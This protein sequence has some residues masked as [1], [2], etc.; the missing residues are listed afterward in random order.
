VWRKPPLV[1]DSG[2]T[3]VTIEASFDRSGYPVGD[4]VRVADEGHP[5]RCVLCER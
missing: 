2:L 4:F 3:L 1:D 5:S